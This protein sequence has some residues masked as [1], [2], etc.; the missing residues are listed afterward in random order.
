[1]SIL[2]EKYLAI[3]TKSSPYHTMLL[4]AQKCYTQHQNCE[5]QTA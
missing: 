3:A 4:H 5:A 2:G 1:M